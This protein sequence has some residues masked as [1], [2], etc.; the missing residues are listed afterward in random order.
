M[1]ANLH[2]VWAKYNRAIEQLAALDKEVTTF[3]KDPRPYGVLAT[4]DRERGRYRFEIRPA[5]Q[6]GIPLRWGVII[7]EIV[8]DLRSA[9]DHLVSQLVVLNK[10]SPDRRHFFPI[11]D[12]EPSR[13][14]KIDTCWDTQGGLKHGPLRGISNEALAVIEAA[15]PYNRDDGVLLS[16]LH[17]LWNA[18]KHRHLAPV[19]VE[20]PPP[21][22]TPDGIMLSRSDRLDGDTYIVH[23]TTSPGAELNVE[24][25]P[26]TDI[27]FG[28]PH[29]IVLELKHV[30]QLILIGIL[31]PAGE[32]FPGLSGVG[33]PDPTPR[34]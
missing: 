30:G 6:A 20:A 26:P 34:P 18:D 2:G 8:H 25:Q 9:L 29:P 15:Q 5:W 33:V 24:P 4:V 11:L 1:A 22:L 28:E 27:T 19:Y 14:F 32:L 12:T 17:F 21:Q 3:C 16:R 23:A 10:G 13:G 31:I 7:G